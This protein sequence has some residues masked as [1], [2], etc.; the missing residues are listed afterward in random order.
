MSSDGWVLWAVR[1]VEINVQL[2]TFSPLNLRFLQAG[3]NTVIDTLWRLEHPGRSYSAPVCGLRFTAL[4]QGS[5]QLMLAK[6]A[7]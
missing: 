3:E 6:T 4:F 1:D 5:I 2:R 7:N